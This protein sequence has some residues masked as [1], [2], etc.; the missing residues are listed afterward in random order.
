[1]AFD[2]IGLNPKDPLGLCYR[3]NIWKWHELW[4]FLQFYC[5]DIIFDINYWYTNDGEEVSKEICKQLLFKLKNQEMINYFNQYL[6][7]RKKMEYMNFET[8]RPLSDQDIRAF[9][10]FLER[11]GGFSIS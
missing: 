4:K 2:L 3:L 10:L 9:C 1:M 11:C 6:S 5:G 7:N 8:Y